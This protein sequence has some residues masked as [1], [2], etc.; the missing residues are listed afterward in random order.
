MAM[1]SSERMEPKFKEEAEAP[2]ITQGSSNTNFRQT[3]SKIGEKV[4]D[5]TAKKVA[6]TIAYGM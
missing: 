5:Q 3:A 1:A 6:S 2:S 4:A